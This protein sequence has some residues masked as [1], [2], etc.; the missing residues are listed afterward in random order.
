[1]KLAISLACAVAVLLAAACTNTAEEAKPHTFPKPTLKGTMSLEETLAARRSVRTLADRPL[2]DE[3]LGQLLWAAQGITQ[4]ARGLRTAPSAGALYPIE[5][6]VFDADGVYHYSPQDHALTL[7][8]AGDQ[9]A[10]LAAAALGQ[11]SVRTNG[12]VILIAAD[13]ARTTRKYGDRAKMYVDIEAGCV[14]Q[15]VLLEA[16]ALG[17]AGVPVGAFRDADVKAV[18]GLPEAETPILLIPIGYRPEE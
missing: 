18:A 6:Y 12:A 7:V 3:Q 13:Y 4:E 14:C 11:G 15:N 9:R 16:V 5:L 10:A 17:L 8:K 1:M 2:T